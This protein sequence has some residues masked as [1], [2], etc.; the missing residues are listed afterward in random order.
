MF[1]LD[2]RAAVCG[3][4][5]EI[6]GV[7]T[8]GVVQE[9]QQARDTY[10]QAVAQGDGAQLLEQKRTDI[11]ELPGR[12]VS[13]PVMGIFELKDGLISGWRDYFDLPGFQAQMA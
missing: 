2:E 4:E 6:D 9:K 1:P 5:V 10:N 12:T 3:F 8:M 13:V 11:F 7:V